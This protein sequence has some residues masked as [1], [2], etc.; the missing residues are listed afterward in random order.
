MH[1]LELLREHGLLR[2]NI[3]YVH[4]NTLPDSEPV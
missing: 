2:P 1:P 4:G 3:L